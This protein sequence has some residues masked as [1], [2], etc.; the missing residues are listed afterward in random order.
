MGTSSQTSP[1]KPNYRAGSEKNIS[2]PV[3]AELFSDIPFG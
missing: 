1:A 2:P 3:E